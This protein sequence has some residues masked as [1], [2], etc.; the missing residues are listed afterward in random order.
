MQSRQPDGRWSAI[1]RVWLA[2]W[3]TLSAGCAAWRDQPPAPPPTV[4]ECPRLP[5]VPVEA[6]EPI[7]SDYLSRTESVFTELLQRLMPLLCAPG[8]GSSG[9]GR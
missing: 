4:V 6:M 7:R 3:L 8:S 9:S 5:P 2:I 1:A